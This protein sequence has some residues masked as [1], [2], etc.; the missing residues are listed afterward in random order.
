DNDIALI[1]LAEPVSGARGAYA[2]LPSSPQVARQFAYDRACTAVTGW[3]SHVGWALEDFV[4]G[5]A[6][7]YEPTPRLQVAPLPVVDTETC[8][9]AN[10]AAFRR[11]GWEPIRVTPR[12]LCAGSGHRGV[13]SCQGDSGGP[14]VAEGGPRGWVQVGIVSW[15][16]GCAQPDTYDVYTRVAAFIPWIRDTIAGP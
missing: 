16:P 8:D 9:A 14:L 1:R 10:R 7:P 6:P 12:M 4:Q 11:V 3:G 2:P 13:G 5:G 15:G